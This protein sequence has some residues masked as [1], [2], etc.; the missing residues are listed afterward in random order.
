[1]QQPETQKLIIHPKTYGNFKGLSLNV[2]VW[3]HKLVFIWRSFIGS[4]SS[5]AQ[6][7]LAPQHNIPN[8]GNGLYLP[9]L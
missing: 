6:T 5:T 9:H 4:L 7:A 1:M 2:V 8:L 3:W